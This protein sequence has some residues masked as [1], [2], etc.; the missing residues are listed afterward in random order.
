LS[1]DQGVQGGGKVASV[2]DNM[3]VLSGGFQFVGLDRGQ[4]AA[5]HDGLR[6]MSLGLVDEVPALGRGS[7]CDATRVDDNELRLIRAIDL[8]E[9][10]RFEKLAN[11]LAFVLVDLAAKG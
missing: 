9:P 1:S 11:L 8:T 6:V 5:D 3:D 2:L 4:T 7:V 10:V